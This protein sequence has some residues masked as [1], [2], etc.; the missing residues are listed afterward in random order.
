MGLLFCAFAL[1]A[2]PVADRHGG[3]EVRTM[4]LPGVGYIRW[5]VLP[6]EDEEPAGEVVVLPSRERSAPDLPSSEP[7]ASARPAAPKRVCEGERGK[8]VARIL[9]QTGL[10]VD[11]EVAGWLERETRFI[12]PGTGYGGLG[13]AP[14][15][16]QAMRNDPIARELAIDLSRCERAQR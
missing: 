13:A 16:I 5:E 3:R 6:G 7:A 9:Q 14:L 11:P 2:A 15:L 10:E 4:V 12:G 8:L 1:L